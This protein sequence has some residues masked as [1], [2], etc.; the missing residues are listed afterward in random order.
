MVIQVENL[1][2]TYQSPFFPSLQAL[3]GLSLKIQPEE[4]V[5]I[6]GATGSGKTTLVQHLNG[7]L[8]PSEGK[9]WIDSIEMKDNEFNVSELRKKVGLVFQ[10]PEIQLFEE[11]V[12]DDVAFAPRNMK[13]SENKVEERVRNALEL[14]G[15]DYDAFRN[16]SPFHL[17]GG[18]KRR[19]AI[20]G[21]L[22][23]E[24][25]VL[26][27]DEPTVSLDLR[28]AMM[29]K[30]IMV[31]YHRSGKTVIFVS[32]D[33]DLVAG[34][35]QRVVVLAKGKI[36]FNGSKEKLFQ[37]NALLKSAGLVLPKVSQFM[38]NMRAKGYSVRVDVFTVE[39]AKEEIRRV[40]KDI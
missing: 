38:L 12:F 30:E 13:L 6:V 40:F 31:Q 28:A 16:C 21:I 25:E 17:S 33:M 22:A 4:I 34:L 7:L 36:V 32:H 2:F 23:M 5:A 20:A 14:V 10:F 29:I 15:L 3:S 26:I 8:Q 27:L 37:D 39:E 35:A 1:F 9:I 18:E 19:V 11:T 24:P